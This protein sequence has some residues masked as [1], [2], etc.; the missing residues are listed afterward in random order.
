MRLF[1]VRHGETEWNKEEIF[2]GRADIPLNEKGRT[3]A[4]RAAN[5]LRRFRIESIYTSPLLRAK[6][7][8]SIIEG[9]TNA[10]LYITD[11][12]IDMDF[13]I[14]EGLSLKEVQEKYPEE[15]EVWKKHPEKW[16]M[17]GET[18]QDVRRRVR[19]GLRILTKEQKKKDGVVIVTHRVICKMIS[20]V[21]LGISNKGFW[22]IKFDPASIS[23][24]DYDGRNYSATLLNGI[25][26]VDE[27]PFFYHDF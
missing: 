15:F 23:I 8:A 4:E 27:D 5:Y 12:F 2:R 16:K 1:V 6:E 26:H 11:E 3:Q 22:R 25:S 17:G 18:L 10:K 9:K 19:E 7:T 20:M 13:G 14:W 21:I 24:F